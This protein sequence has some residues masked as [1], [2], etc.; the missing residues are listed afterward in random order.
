LALELASKL[1]YPASSGERIMRVISL[2]GILIFS[3]N[4]WALEPCAAEK[5][6]VD[7]AN[8]SIRDSEAERVALSTQINAEGERRAG[9]LRESLQQSEAKLSAANNN[10]LKETRLLDVVQSS[11]P[12][13]ARWTELA[14][15]MAMGERDLTVCLNNQTSMPFSQCVAA[16]GDSEDWHALSRLVRAL[17]GSRAWSEQM[18]TIRELAAENEKILLP[19]LEKIGEMQDIL[20]ASLADPALTTLKQQ[21]SQAQARIESSLQSQRAD[22]EKSAA[23]Q[24]RLAGLRVALPKQKTALNGCMRREQFGN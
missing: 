13:L 22:E 21:V 11:R 14:P 5:A 24:K 4:C 2:L 19:L 12:L 18:L 3:I 1:L 7:E 17:E 23:L 20:G 6:S 16:A 10:V 8:N 9:P 15:A